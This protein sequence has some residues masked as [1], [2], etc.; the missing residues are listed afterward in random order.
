MSFKYCRAYSWPNHKDRWPISQAHFEKMTK[1]ARDIETKLPCS[2]AIIWAYELEDSPFALLAL[3][4]PYHQAADSGL[5]RVLDDFERKLGKPA[6]QSLENPGWWST[7]V[8]VNYRSTLASYG[9]TVLEGEFYE[10]LGKP[11]TEENGPHTGARSDWRNA[12]AKIRSKISGENRPQKIRFKISG[13]NSFGKQ[14]LLI[15]DPSSVVDGQALRDDLDPIFSRVNPSTDW[16]QRSQRGPTWIVEHDQDGFDL[17]IG[18][19]V[20]PDLLGSL[21]EELSKAGYEVSS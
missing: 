2:F 11:E 14:Q 5:G 17:P 9:I 21:L 18:V 3:D 15:V 1:H 10:V 4:L 19:S 7:S 16:F 8:D 12:W 13:M 20:H 6:P